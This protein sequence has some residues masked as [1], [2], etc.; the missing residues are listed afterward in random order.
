MAEYEVLGEWWLPE[1]AE[2]RLP[3]RLVV[4]SAHGVR[5]TLIGGSV[6]EV[7]EVIAV[8]S[9]AF[10]LDAA[11]LSTQSADAGRR[12]IRRAASLSRNPA[13]R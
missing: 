10:N 2:R 4:D 1:R 9:G 3:G 11:P 13:V 5:L 6:R 12:S 7:P 8:E